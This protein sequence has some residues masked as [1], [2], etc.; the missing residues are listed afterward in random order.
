MSLPAGYVDPS[1]AGE[2]QAV[3]AAVFQVEGAAGVFDL[4]G[5]M[6]GAR[7]QEG[8]TGG[9]LRRPEP[10]TVSLGDEHQFTLV[11]SVL[12]HGHIVRGVVLQ[13]E[14]MRGGDLASSIAQVIARH[15]A[16]SGG[17]ADASA[18]LTAIRDLVTPA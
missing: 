10:P 3:L 2:I 6:P 17:V 16:D 18:A 11:D 1:D 13:R 15:V 5:R 4:L 14:R 9:R 12:E 7:I 8:T